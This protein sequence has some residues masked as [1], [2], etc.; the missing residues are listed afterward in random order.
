MKYKESLF[1]AIVKE[2]ETVVEQILRDMAQDLDVFQFMQDYAWVLDSVE[3]A[4]PKHYNWAQEVCHPL[5]DYIKAEMETQSIIRLLIPN[6]LTLGVDFSSVDGSLIL[7]QRSAE[8]IN[9]VLPPDIVALY[10]PVSPTIDPTDPL[11][12]LESTLGVPFLTNLL[13]IIRHRI[14]NIDPRELS[15]YIKSIL[16]GI[17]A[18]TQICL[19]Q[20]IVEILGEDALFELLDE[21]SPLPCNLWMADVVAAAGGGAEVVPDFNDPSKY[22]ITAKGQQLLYSI[23]SPYVTYT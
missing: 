10:Y 5:F 18:R 20:Y 9:K 11:G 3:L 12:S 15:Y 2:N 19:E 14:S 23:V 4:A 1:N 22:I 13:F 21:E 8:V 17:F 6:K 16:E 7:S